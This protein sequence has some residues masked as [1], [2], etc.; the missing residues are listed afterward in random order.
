MGKKH[1]KSS[2]VSLLFGVC[3][4]FYLINQNYSQLKY[5]HIGVEKCAKICHKGEKRGSQLEIWQN[6]KHSKS[7][8]TLATPVAKEVLKTLGDEGEPQKSEKCLPCHSTGYGLDK[9]NFAETFKIEDGV[10]CEACHGQGSV[11]K[12]ISIMKDRKK[13]LANGGIIPKEKDCL[14]CHTEKVHHVK[15]FNFDEMFKKITHPVPKK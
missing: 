1:L 2:A 8:V 5:K 6:S 11:Y 9:S 7:F 3:L 12:S 13:F 15:E 14:K 10:T 4:I